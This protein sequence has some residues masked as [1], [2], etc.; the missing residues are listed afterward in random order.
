M[1]SVVYLYDDVSRL[2]DGADEFFRIIAE[3]FNGGVAL[4]VHFGEKGN[5]THVR[6]EWLKGAASI[7]DKPVFVDCNVL[8]RGGRT[9]MIDHLN[10]A[11]QHGF[12]FLPLHILDGPV[13]EDTLEV[14][15]VGG[16][17]K[18]AKLG[19]G[20]GDYR[21]LVAVS[22]FK[23]HIATGFGGAL[24]NIGM[25]LGSRPGK[26]E[27]HSVISPKVSSD[28]CVSCGTCVNECPGDA[29]S[30]QGPAL[31][32]SSKCIGC[33]RCIAVCPHAAIDIPWDLS[34][35]VNKVLMERIA[36]YAQ[37][38]LRGREWWFMSFITDVTADCDCMPYAQ[39]PIADDVGILLSKD[40]VAVDMASIDL[41]SR[42]NGGVDP[43]L[44]K[45]GIDGRHMLDYAAEIGL[46]SQDYAVE[47]VTNP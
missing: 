42:A 15:I 18:T 31:I 7:L 32:D 37:A 36:E 45:H 40:P 25:G 1:S 44:A 43:F 12:G 41:V 11:R 17:L 19:A 21:Q 13:G 2:R 20:L 33:A 34:D 5:T 10:V 46:G 47:N 26:L 35:S 27:M 14:P 24:K 3:S 9:R 28:K 29:I 30:L 23:G 4:K 22:H 38:A 6:P 16:M 8:Y 39:K